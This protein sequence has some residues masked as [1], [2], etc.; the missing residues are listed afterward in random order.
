MDG[1][2]L[3]SYAELAGLAA[4]R[5]KPISLKQYVT[6]AEAVRAGMP[7]TIGPEADPRNMFGSAV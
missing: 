5:D 3:L 2:G 1:D 7:P 6:M 4:V